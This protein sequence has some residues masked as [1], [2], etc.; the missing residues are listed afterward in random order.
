M[1]AEQIIKEIEALPKRERERLV[2]RMRE[3][4]SGEIPRI[5]STPLRISRRNVSLQW[6]Q[7]LTKRPG[8]VSYRCRAVIEPDLRVIFRIDGPWV[9]T[10][11]VRT[12]K[13]YRA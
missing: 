5:S 12:R 10:L 2:Q 9:A 6:K 1:T 7:H 3:L 4:G 11:D 13:V 8:L